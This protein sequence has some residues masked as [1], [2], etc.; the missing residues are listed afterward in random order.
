MRLHGRLAETQPVRHLD[1][2]QPRGDVLEHLELPLG[3]RLVRA[4]SALPGY[5]SPLPPGQPTAAPAPAAGTAVGG[6]R[7]P[8]TTAISVST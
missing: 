3:Q 4:R 6:G 5:R 2:R 1:V 8:G 7:R